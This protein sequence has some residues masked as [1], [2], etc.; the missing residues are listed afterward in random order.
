MAI[1]RTCMCQP[2][3]LS[4]IK[5]SK[6]WIHKNNTMN[7]L[8]LLYQISELASKPTEDQSTSIPTS[9]TEWLTHAHK[10]RVQMKVENYYQNLKE[11]IKRSLKTEQK[12]RKEEHFTKKVRRIWMRREKSQHVPTKWFPIDFNVMLF[13]GFLFSILNQKLWVQGSKLS[14]SVLCKKENTK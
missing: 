13:A 9:S 7:E 14:N 1:N 2:G 3:E 5:Y 8:P 12:K 6:H 4:S 10:T 11:N